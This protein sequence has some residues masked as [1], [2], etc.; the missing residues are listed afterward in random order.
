[1]MVDEERG[2]CGSGRE[3]GKKSGRVV[4]WWHGGGARVGVG[5]A[6]CDATVLLHGSALRH[7]FGRYHDYDEC[8]H[9]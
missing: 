2:R 9:E 1:M 8:Q 7:E 6:V 3:G 4:A 5:G